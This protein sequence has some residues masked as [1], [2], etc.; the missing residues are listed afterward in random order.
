MEIYGPI[1]L[2]LGIVLVVRLLAG[3]MDTNRIEE[4]ISD[5]GGRLTK[6]TWTPFGPGWFGEKS[7][8]IYEITY[9]DKNGNTRHAHVKTSL[10]SGVYLTN[11]E[12]LEASGTQ[13]VAD[14][15]IA[16]E[17]E[18]AELRKRLAELEQQD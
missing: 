10:F 6:K 15:R 13:E 14:A 3:A 11:E 8:R 5:R 16:L 12:V 2:V 17:L 9:E 18:N 4:H 7:D 1:I